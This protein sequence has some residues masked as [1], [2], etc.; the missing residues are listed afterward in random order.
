MAS[1]VAP[2]GEEL[3]IL[4]LEVERLIQGRDWER[5]SEICELALPQL[6]HADWEQMCKEPA[7]LREL[8]AVCTAFSSLGFAAESN[9]LS[10]VLAC[11]LRQPAI[12]PST[13]ASAASSLKQVCYLSS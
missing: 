5:A 3:L 10:E 9:G 13:L 8:V 1:N 6:I 11:A 4:R 12:A 7:S 2:T